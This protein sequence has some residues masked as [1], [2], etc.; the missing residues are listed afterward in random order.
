MSTRGRCLP[1]RAERR[2]PGVTRALTRQ[3]R[4]SEPEVNHLVERY[5]ALKSLR[6][7]AAELGID[8]STARSHLKA[9]GVTLAPPASM[10]RADVTAAIELYA[11]GKSSAAIGRTLGFTNKTVIKELRAADVTIRPQVGRPR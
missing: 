10:S 5:L 7:V 3:R 11:E 6:L 1:W 8:R 4:L 9:R 2:A